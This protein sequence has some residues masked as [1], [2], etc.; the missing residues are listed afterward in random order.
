M[1]DFTFTYGL[2]GKPGYS[3][4]RPFDYFNFHVTA[5]TANTMESLNTRGLLLGRA[6]ESGDSIRGVWGLFGSFDYIHLTACIP[7]VQ[8]RPLARDDLAIVVVSYGGAPG[9]GSGR[10]AASS[11]RGER[12]YHYGATP[13][14]LLALRLIFG[15]RAMIDLTAREYYV[16][17]LL[18]SEQEKKTCCV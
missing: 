17:S 15:D 11:A 4:A 13:Q 1:A 14:G 9:H 5:V 12:D 3:Y 18:A 7:A 16:G 8:H 6:Y 2:P 10:P